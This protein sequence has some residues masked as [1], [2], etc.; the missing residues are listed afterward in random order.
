M[1]YPKSSFSRLSVTATERADMMQ[2]AAVAFISDQFKADSDTVDLKTMTYQDFLA[3][4]ETADRNGTREQ[5][6][7]NLASQLMPIVEQVMMASTQP[8]G[9]ANAGA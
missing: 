8:E 3:A 4:L 6:E 2:G 5:F 1:K 7:A 9:D